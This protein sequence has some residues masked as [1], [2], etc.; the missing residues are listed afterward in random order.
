MT[1]LRSSARYC[2]KIVC[3]S[4]LAANN[5]LNPCRRYKSL[6]WLT[7]ICAIWFRP[8]DQGTVL[9]P[10]HRPIWC[11]SF[12]RAVGRRLLQRTPP[13]RCGCKA[14]LYRN[15]PSESLPAKQT[16]SIENVGFFYGGDMPSFNTIFFQSIESSLSKT[17]VV[18]QKVDRCRRSGKKQ[19]WIHLKTIVRQFWCVSKDNFF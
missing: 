13:R 6:D 18:I 12:F 17:S 9:H 3:R 7:M 5:I 14:R 2:R 16:Y 11:V 10:A 1:S 15:I 4:S 19:I 8:G